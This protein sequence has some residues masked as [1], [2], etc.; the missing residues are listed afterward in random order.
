MYVQCG[1]KCMN[2]VLRTKYVRCSD[3]WRG[4]GQMLFLKKK[5]DFGKTVFLYV[6]GQIGV[7]LLNM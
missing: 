3:D 6:I 2:F 7:G 4:M 1:E 5:H